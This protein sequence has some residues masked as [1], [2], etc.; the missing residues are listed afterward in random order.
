MNQE[1]ARQVVE[2]IG[3]AKDELLSALRIAESAG[4]SKSLI[5]SLNSLC[6][7][8]ESIQNKPLK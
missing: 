3:K 8:V 5:K 2:R 1:E 7:K 6:G 4:A